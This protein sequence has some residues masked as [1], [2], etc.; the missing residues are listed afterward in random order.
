M[1]LHRCLRVGRYLPL[2]LETKGLWTIIR[3]V[4]LCSSGKPGSRGT[5]HAGIPAVEQCG[6]IALKTPKERAWKHGFLYLL[7]LETACPPSCSYQREQSLS[8]TDMSDIQLKLLSWRL[9]FSVSADQKFQ[10]F[11]KYSQKFSQDCC[12]VEMTR[13]SKL[14]YV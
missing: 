13:V 6:I 10:F 5:D 4:G 11:F 1:L 9:R 3:F 14:K 7:I 2:I 12:W 8:E